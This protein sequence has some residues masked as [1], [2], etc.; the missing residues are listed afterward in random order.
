MPWET[1]ISYQP[2][3][4]ISLHFC[5]FCSKECIISSLSMYMEKHPKA[6]RL[7]LPS[8]AH[9]VPISINESC[10]QALKLAPGLVSPEQQRSQKD[11]NRKHPLPIIAN[12]LHANISF[13]Y[14]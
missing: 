11:P 5:S 9:A 8:A 13:I 10:T 12:S 7:T 2:L 4:E 14:V 3:S 6:L 1:K